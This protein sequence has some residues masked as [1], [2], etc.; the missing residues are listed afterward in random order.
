MNFK[1]K[2][3]IV[4]GASSGIGAAV[5]IALSAEGASV[6]IVGRNQAKLAATAARCTNALAI[7]ADVTND[8]DAQRIIHQTVVT[9]GKIDVL[10][11]NAGGAKLATVF[12]ENIM[13]AYDFTM[14]VNLRAVFR[15]TSLAVPYLMK[16]KGN[17][18]NMS[19]VSGHGV[20]FSQSFISYSVSKAGLSHFGTCLAAE[21]APH[22]VRVNTITPGPVDTDILKNSGLSLKWDDL[23]S[24]TALDKVSEPQEIA[25]LILFVASDKGK[26]FTGSNIF[27]DNGLMIKH[28]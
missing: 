6:A 13:A 10:V 26:S 4:T 5:A 25:D 11:N 16:T 27:C 2:V 24:K 18:V 9:F 12:D 1:G 8:D 17:I 20:Q 7:Q 15:I 23:K 14:N 21:L 19:S 3:A 28:S 22:G